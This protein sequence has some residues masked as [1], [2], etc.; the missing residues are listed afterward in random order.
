MISPTQYRS[1]QVAQ[2][3]AAVTLAQ[4]GLTHARAWKPPEE[5]AS[6]FLVLYIG[7]TS[8]TARKLVASVPKGECV[9]GIMGR[10][11]AWH[12]YGWD[13]EHRRQAIARANALRAWAEDNGTFWWP[14]QGAGPSRRGDEVVR[15]VTCYN[16]V[17]IN[18]ATKLP[19]V[20]DAA[21]IAQTLAQDAFDDAISTSAICLDMENYDGRASWQPWGNAYDWPEIKR[22]FQSATTEAAATWGDTAQLVL[23]S[24][25]PFLPGHTAEQ[26]HEAFW[27]QTALRAFAER[28]CAVA[29]NAD[30]Y[31]PPKA[32]GVLGVLGSRDWRRWIDDVLRHAI[33]YAEHLP[34]IWH[35]PVVNL[36]IS[37][38]GDREL[39][40]QVAEM[41]TLA[42]REAGHIAGIAIYMRGLLDA[43][44]D[45]AMVRLQQTLELAAGARRRLTWQR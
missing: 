41:L 36:N 7:D 45:D 31:A 6:P 13:D 34:G 38:L 17:L 39:C 1:L 12:H 43:L 21:F 44:G 9:L 15:Q 37:D 8:A 23:L 30:H 3:Q 16:G 18:G 5:Q 33:A 24:P 2:W 28:G 4:D 42:A 22:A 10:P 25:R 35:V 14:F 32:G 20:H 19:Y 29:L 27:T 40:R 11:G 26:R